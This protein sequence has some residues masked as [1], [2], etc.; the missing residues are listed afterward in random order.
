MRSLDQ[1]QSPSLLKR[2]K[3]KYEIK[4]SF[5]ADMNVQGQFDNWPQIGWYTRKVGNSKTRHTQLWPLSF[6]IFTHQFSRMFCAISLPI[7][8]VVWCTVLFTFHL[9]LCTFGTVLRIDRWC[10]VYS[11]NVFAT[12][13][14]YKRQRET[15]RLFCDAVTIWKMSTSLKF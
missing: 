15:C 9:L 4:M 12:I 7:M 10:N 13:D 1:K 8:P 14:V 3:F 5:Y 2:Q 11:F 6:C